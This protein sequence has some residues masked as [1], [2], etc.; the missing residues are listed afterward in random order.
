MYRKRPKA[1]TS[2]LFVFIFALPFSG[3]AQTIH[4]F[5]RPMG[6]LADSKKGNFSSFQAGYSI[7]LPDRIGGFDGR[8]GILN[9][10]RLTEGYYFVGIEDRQSKVEGTALFDAETDKVI[11]G[12]FTDAARDLFATKFEVKSVDRK[13]ITFDGHLGK[14]IRTVLTDVIVLIRVFWIENRAY[15]LASILTPDQTR[16]ESK[17]SEVFDSLKV[18]ARQ[19]TDAAVEKKILA[20]TPESLPQ[21]PVIVRGTSDA[22]DEGLKGKVK[23]VRQESQFIKGIKAGSPSQMD[24][25]ETYNELGDLVKR[26]SYDDTDGLPFEISVFGYLEGKRVSKSKM[27][28]YGGELSSAGPSV[29]V[30]AKQRDERYGYSYRYR[31][32][33]NN[34]LT[35]KVMFDSAGN[36]WI[37]TTFGYSGNTI[38]V[39][40]YDDQGKVNQRSQLTLDSTGNAIEKRYFDSPVPGWTS[41]YS[42]KYDLFDSHGNW[43][44][45]SVTESRA[46]GGKSREEWTMVE[47]RNID[48]F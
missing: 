29:A 46:V 8:R 47:Q 21:K 3:L 7:A 6:S 39:T 40:A 1:K 33:K 27:I 41:T 5:L 34:R 31:Y 44:K 25:E 12:L 30:K 24:F 26:I 23:K 45:R 28:F 43:T 35:E 11:D 48:Y 32:D 22:Q 37:R 14:E 13:S 15:K 18:V 20:N 42:Y 17:V 9:N 38:E 16:F 36:I 19:S 4:S 2:I 10:W